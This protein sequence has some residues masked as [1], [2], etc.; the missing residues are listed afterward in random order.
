M[1]YDCAYKQLEWMEYDCD[2]FKQVEMEVSWFVCT[3]LSYNRKQCTFK[4]IAILMR[5][6]QMV[7]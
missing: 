2:S 1:E 7:T 6:K 4:G 5:N 3:N